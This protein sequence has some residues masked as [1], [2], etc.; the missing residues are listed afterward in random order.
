M[1]HV[2]K[3]RNLLLTVAWTVKRKIKMKKTILAFVLGAFLSVLA[4]AQIQKDITISINAVVAP[5]VV[6]AYA[7]QYN[8]QTE[9][10]DGEGNLIPNP[11]S[12]GQF[13]LRILGEETQNTV[14]SIYI[15][16]MRHLGSEVAAAQANQ[17]AFNITVQ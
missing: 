10:R 15:S 4:F 3:M 11:E 1:E 12:K 8:Y 16:Y 9:I 6:D 7:W 14:R 17:D 5:D 2:P 13:A